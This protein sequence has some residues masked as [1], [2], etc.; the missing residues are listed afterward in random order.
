MF[1]Y[2]DYPNILWQWLLVLV[3]LTH[4]I[5]TV[6]QESSHSMAAGIMWDNMTTFR[7]LTA[8]ILFD[9]LATI[10]VI[11]LT[12]CIIY[13]LSILYSYVWYALLIISY[14]SS[15][16]HCEMIVEGSHQYTHTWWCY[17]F[18]GNVKI[19]EQFS[20]RELDIEYLRLTDNFINSKLNIEYW[21]K[22]L[23]IEIWML[24]IKSIFNF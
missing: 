15:S 17:C 9:L 18:Y 5:T 19:S 2:I 13:H 22:Y 3:L 1:N 12:V 10:Y 24:T 14:D 4:D 11:N 16:S 20:F 21:L 23:E 8:L 6:G 7:L